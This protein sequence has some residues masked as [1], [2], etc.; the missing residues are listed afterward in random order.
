MALL[1]N[2]LF[3]AFAAPAIWA[4]VNIIDVYFSKEV[5]QDEY[6]AVIITGA[7]GI[8]PWILTPIFGFSFPEVNI[9]L[10]ALGGGICF[11]LS[12]WF[13]FRALFVIGDTALIQV[14]WNTTAIVVPVLAFFLIKEKLSEIQ[15][16]GIVVT[17]EGLMTLSVVGGSTRENMTKILPSM[18][19]AIIFFSL[20]LIAQE[21]V[22]TQTTFW[23]G[24]LVFTLG[25]FFG[26]V[27]FLIARTIQ[28]KTFHLIKMNK[29]Y[30]RWFL[31]TEIINV[32]GIVCS[33]RAISLAPAISFVAVI[34]SLMPAFIIL[35]SIVILL[36]LKIFSR[37]GHEIMERIHQEQT[38]GFRAKA[39][40]IAIMATGIYLINLKP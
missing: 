36:F 35:E 8:L 25:I 38:A 28:G 2:W 1:S 34:E 5:F 26:S 37:N 31:G 32:V 19:G 3:M 4:L 17:F 6:D 20:S 23:N 29:Y 40:A 11:L 30:I 27:L 24:L 15:Y 9:T 39:L 13:Y 10:L 12:Y 14:L 21:K 18:I 16:I 33:Q 7:F 22:Y